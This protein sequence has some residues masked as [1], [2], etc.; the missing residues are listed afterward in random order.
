MEQCAFQSQTSRWKHF[1]FTNIYEK[2]S[3]RSVSV[4][5][6]DV[7]SRFI[8]NAERNKRLMV[9]ITISV[10]EK[11]Q[12]YSFRRRAIVNDSTLERIWTKGY[13]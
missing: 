6:T 13:I 5:R 2:I 9:F 1:F 4:L 11:A 8:S 12:Q 7:I 10:F 3:M